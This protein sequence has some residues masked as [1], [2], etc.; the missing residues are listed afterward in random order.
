ME[1]SGE[2]QWT[3]YAFA[4]TE[5]EHLF[6]WCY[7]KDGS[8]DVGDDCFFVDAIRF[9]E[10]NDAKAGMPQRSFR[11]FELFRRRAEGAPVLLASHLTDTVFMETG[12]NNLP[13]GQ[14]CWGVSCHYE[15]NREQYF[16]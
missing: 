2:T 14:Y 15:G 3:R 4:V 13:W 16:H 1:V 12:W 7:Q 5:G 6:R 11:Y 9:Y 10:E 8:T